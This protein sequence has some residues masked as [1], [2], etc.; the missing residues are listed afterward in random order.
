M[1][2]ND[3]LSEGMRIHF[4]LFVMKC[5][6]TLHPGQS[7]LQ[8]TWYLKAICFQLDRVYRG[9]LRR[10]VINVP[11]RHLKSITVSVAYAAWLL[12]KDPATKIL[13]ASYSQDLARMHS[14][15]TRAI[16]E[17]DWYRELFPDTQISNRGNRQG[18]LVTTKGGYRKAVSVG[19]TVT[20][21]GADIIIV[22]DLIKADDAQSPASRE[23]ARRWFD[24]SLI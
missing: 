3:V 13:V 17:C 21:H 10:L 19:G 18:E 12:G 14:E 1:T 16:L 15:H 7:P 20:G 4:S 8:L 2:E 24:N 6:E 23:R 9:A 22:D 11:P 5:F